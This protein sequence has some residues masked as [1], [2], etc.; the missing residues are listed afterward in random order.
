MNMQT[1]TL[2]GKVLSVPGPLWLVGLFFL[3]F[4][5]SPLQLQAE[6]LYSGK[7]SDVFKENSSEFSNIE[8]LEAIAT[9]ARDGQMKRIS[10]FLLSA[11]TLAAG[12]HETL[13]PSRLEAVKTYFAKEI[14][15]A[16]VTG[17]S[18]AVPLP[19]AYGGL[20]NKMKTPMPMEMP[21]IFT[22]EGERSKDAERQPDPETEVAEPAPPPLEDWRKALLARYRK[23]EKA[24]RPLCEEP[25]PD[26]TYYGDDCSSSSLSER[27][28]E[29]CIL[30][31]NIFSNRE[32]SLVPDYEYDLERMVQLRRTI[33]EVVVIADEI[34]ERTGL[35][36]AFNNPIDALNREIESQ[37]LAIKHMERSI[38]KLYLG[39]K[40][41]GIM[42]DSDDNI[43]NLIQTGTVY[44][45]WSTFDRGYAIVYS[46]LTRKK[47]ISQ[48]RALHNYVRVNLGL[49][50]VEENWFF[51]ICVVTTAY[52]DKS[53]P[54]TIEEADRRYEAHMVPDLLELGI[55][56]IP[57]E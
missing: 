22:V 44:N 3:L 11:T 17:E 48:V 14:P 32:V 16:V 13:G 56:D 35:P 34:V 4:Q 10:V 40:A 38:E 23:V 25:R 20:A 8:I 54:Q 28:F 1:D 24:H 47:N 41:L 46:I 26:P 57:L 31:G 45:N 29:M 50:E 12:K 37:K 49:D 42:E 39:L 5:L 53:F 19:S 43:S 21:D 15:G 36:R 6:M 18:Q 52:L 51:P 9:K 2:S 27:E 33:K 55:E 7:S 30:R